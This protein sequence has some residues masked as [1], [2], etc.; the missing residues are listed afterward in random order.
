[1]PSETMTIRELLTNLQKFPRA[2]V[3]RIERDVVVPTPQQQSAARKRELLRRAVELGVTTVDA[4][5]PRY[6][7][8]SAVAAA[9]A[10]RKKRRAEREARDARF[11]TQ[12]DE[13]VLVSRDIPDDIPF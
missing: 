13:V 8:S 2:E 10:A 9:E 12:V 7:L 3:E 4:D 5:T 11:T 6:E 1:M